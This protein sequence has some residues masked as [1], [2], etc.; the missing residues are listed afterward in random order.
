MYTETGW[1]IIYDEINPEQL[2]HE[3]TVLMTGNG[4]L[5][6]RGSLAVRYPGQNI[7]TFVHGLYDDIAVSFTELVNIPNWTSFQ[8]QID[9][10]KLDLQSGELV[11]IKH[12]LDMKSGTLYLDFVWKNNKGQETRFHF[13]RFASL[14]EIHL[15]CQRLEITPLNYSA[16]IEVIASLDGKTDNLGFQHWEFL[17]QECDTGILSL[18]LK[19][20]ETD[21]T[22]AMSQSLRTMGLTLI[23]KEY[24]N[25]DQHPSQRLVFDGKVG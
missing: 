13:E 2:N 17:S 18:E 3:E 20:K 12:V 16:E 8:I 24:W 25:L 1:E 10:E 7:A 21:I 22:L 15:L 23:T 11:A 9:G 19:T 5:S 6:T 14:A 4:Y